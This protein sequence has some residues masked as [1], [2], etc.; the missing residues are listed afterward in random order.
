VA[1]GYAAS[2]T[3]I[4]PLRAAPLD[5]DW[6]PPVVNTTV[7]HA[8]RVYDYLLGGKDN[9]PADR[10]VAERLVSI[11]PSARSAARETRRFLGRAVRD[12]A[13]QRGIRQFVDVGMGFPTTGGTH[14][15]LRTVAPEARIV[16]VD[17][18]PVVLAH[19]R[20]LLRPLP[21]GQAALVDADLRRP[22]ELLDTARG[23]LD[24]EQ[25]IAVL[26]CAVL[27]FLTADD[28]PYQLVRRL[29]EPLPN[30][31]YVVISH[32]YDDADSDRARQMER[33][34]QRGGAGTLVMRSLEDVERFFDGLT[35]LSP[36]VVPVV[37]W[38]PNE[39]ATLGPGP[40]E[41]MVC[42]GVAQK[43]VR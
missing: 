24:F 8:A 32:G 6:Q 1:C 11:L 40:S 12:L 29:V 7:A 34:Y 2:V 37:D 16:Y 14:D 30:G 33:G 5:P 17:N 38:M 3:D 41:V 28:D 25:P 36:G 10:A 39:D 19:A 22:E 20:A 15:V 18:D 26:L 9:F 42:G 4:S 23:T 31:S 43:R 13:E 27:H 21:A 35:L